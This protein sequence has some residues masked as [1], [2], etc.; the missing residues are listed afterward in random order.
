MILFA[1]LCLCGI[2][3]SQESDYFN[4]RHLR[5]EDHIYR[6]NIHTVILEQVN[7]PLSDPI[8]EPGTGE[9]LKLTFD[10]LDADGKDYAYKFFHC[11]SKWNLS[12]IDETEFLNGF[13]SDHITSFKPSFNTVQPYYHYFTVFPTSQ[14]QFTKSGNYVIMVYENSEPDIPVV[15]H[16]FQIVESHVKILPNLHRAVVVDQRNSSQE[17]DFNIQYNNYVIQSPFSE[18]TVVIRQNGRWDNA[19]YDIKPLFMKQNELEYNYEDVNVFNGG[20]EFR[21]FDAR[22]VKFQT[23]FVKNIELDS[24]GSYHIY[25][26]DDESRSFKRYSIEDDIDGRYLIKMYDGNDSE[27]ESDYVTVHF[28][29]KSEDVMPNGNY[30]VFGSLTNWQTEPFAK[31]HY[32]YEESAYETSLLLKQG[33]YNYEYVFLED[34][35][36]IADETMIEGNHF[37]T[38]NEYT[39]LVYQQPPG[40]RYQKLIGYK[41]FSSKNIY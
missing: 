27:T 21:N 13:Y 36:K 7:H 2:T 22:T 24:A 33:Y 6:P 32:N 10:D 26:K 20:N 16:R 25:L 40:S 37:E 11:D 19:V 28:R 1:S 34:G 14:M 8:I 23:Q 35:K 3:F 4:D 31:L 18:I 17:I 29:L 12:S 38:E 5:Y 9:Q 15:T 39:L 41:K 30:Y